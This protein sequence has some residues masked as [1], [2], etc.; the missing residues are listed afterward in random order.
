MIGTTD[1]NSY[2]NKIQVEDQCVN[3]VTSWRSC[4]GN[5]AC[6]NT[7]PICVPCEIEEVVKL[8][9]IRIGMHV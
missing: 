3:G 2:Y 4:K 7:F 5:K 9:F 6:G 8:C 1:F